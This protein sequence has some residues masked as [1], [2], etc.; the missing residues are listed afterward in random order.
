[1]E[2]IS[3]FVEDRLLIQLALLSGMSKWGEI[4]SLCPVQSVELLN[5]SWVSYLVP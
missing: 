4:T 5:E 3:F 2:E 1:V